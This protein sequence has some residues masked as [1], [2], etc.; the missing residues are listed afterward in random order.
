MPVQISR[1]RV[2]CRPEVGPRRPGGGRAPRS[3]SSRRQKKRLLFHLAVTFTLRR[4]RL[5]S[6][7][8]FITEQ[9][10][11]IPP[12]IRREAAECKVA[13]RLISQRAF[14]NFISPDK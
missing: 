6:S 7:A 10:E 1:A 2:G 9:A 11:R 5:S 12:V 3:P 8:C 4:V 13:H 14:L